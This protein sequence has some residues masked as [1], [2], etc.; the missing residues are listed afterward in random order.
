M[1]PEITLITPM[2]NEED[3]IREN[4]HKLINK[5][6]LL[7]VSWEYL[8]IDDGSTDNSKALAE[9]AFSE[10]P[11]CRMIHYFPNKGRGY[12]LQQGFAAAT[13]NYIITTEADLSWGEDIISEI[14][15][16]LI[17]TGDDIIIASTYLS[18]GGHINVPIFRRKLSSYGN[19]ILRT[20][21]GG[22]LT[23][24][25]GMTR[26]YRRQAIQSIYLTENEKHI[27]LEIISKAH[28]LEH[29]ISEIPGEIYWSPKKSNQSFAKL[30]GILKHVLPHILSSMTEGALKV[31]VTASTFFLL[32]GSAFIIFGTLNKLLIITDVPKPNLIIYGFSFIILG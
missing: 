18:G 26:G 8:L 12:A 7:G 9:A 15:Q 27:H 29:T 3:C 10:H 6:E 21:F 24:F 25:S 19:K 1:N 5:L 13:G 31:I 30:S 17:R 22:K 2:Y 28:H 20:C 32:L 11:N 4:I 16:A 14:Y 23:M